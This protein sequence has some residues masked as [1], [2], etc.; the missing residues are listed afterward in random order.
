MFLGLDFPS[1][2]QSWDIVPA[3]RRDRELRHWWD[4]LGCH[5][6]AGLF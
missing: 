2:A 3:L 1:G 5:G 6:E 4:I